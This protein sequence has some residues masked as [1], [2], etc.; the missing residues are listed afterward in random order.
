M[1]RS[2][3]RLVTRVALTLL[4]MIGATSCRASAVPA[5]TWTRHADP[6]DK[7][8]GRI[9]VLMFPGVGDDGESYVDHGFVESLQ[10]ER[11]GVDIVTVDARRQYFGARTLLARIEKDVLVPA[12]RRGYA[13]IWIVGLSMGG[14]GALLTARHFERDI[15]G[16]ILFAPYLGHRRV[17]GRIKRAGGVRKWK[18][19]VGRT[20]WT[21]D[22]WRWLRGYVEAE[23]RPRIYLASGTEDMWA[24]AHQL[25]AEVVPAGH[26]FSRP[27]GHKWTVWSPLWRQMLDAGVIRTRP[28]ADHGGSADHVPS[29][30]DVRPSRR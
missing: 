24:T 8:A 21:I 13:Q 14:A 12:R 7:V 18:P 22:L 25:L 20:T 1:S 2:I 6:D 27:G 29:R 5:L 19:P 3:T 15:D 26:V 4:L 9:L 17:I 16:L 11:R 23:N 10:D 30:A 28:A